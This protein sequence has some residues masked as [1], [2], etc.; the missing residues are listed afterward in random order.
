MVQSG[1]VTPIFVLNRVVFG[2]FFN[3]YCLIAAVLNRFPA[4]EDNGHVAYDTWNEPHHVGFHDFPH[5]KS[6]KIYTVDRSV[7]SM[8]SLCGTSPSNDLKT[9]TTSLIVGPIILYC[10]R[11]DS[12]RSAER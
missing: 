10:C 9:I 11:T 7:H 3:S 4:L 12:E 2:L 5:G 1:N 8:H 6:K